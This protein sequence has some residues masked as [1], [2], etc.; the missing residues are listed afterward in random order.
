MMQGNDRWP[1]GIVFE[2][3]AEPLQLILTQIAFKPNLASA[4]ARKL[5]VEQSRLPHIPMAW[6][7]WTFG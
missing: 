6:V 1:M 5:R 7:G 2:F 3:G 4:Q